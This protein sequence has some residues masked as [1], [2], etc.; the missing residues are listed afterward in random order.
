MDAVSDE[1]EIDQSFVAP[2][3]PKPD[4]GWPRP[5]PTAYPMKPSDVL[6]DDGRL[7]SGGLGR[8]K[9]VQHEHRV[10]V[11][12]QDG[13]W[14]VVRPRL[15]QPTGGPGGAARA[16]WDCPHCGSH[17]LIPIVYGMP[18]PELAEAAERNEL[19]LGGCVVS[20]DDPTHRC[21]NCG[22][23]LRVDV[24]QERQHPG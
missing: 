9:L 19:V 12:W 16:S 17:E 6:L 11:K 4:K 21:R 5:T 10:V 8:V 13:E 2:P 22:R 20:S 18:G 3:T 23:D 24:K 14:V 15:H 1:D 7:Y